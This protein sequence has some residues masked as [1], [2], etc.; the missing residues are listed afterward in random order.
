M[1]ELT[2][3]NEEYILKIRKRIHEYWNSVDVK[4]YS[5]ICL[6]ASINIPKLLV[7]Q[8]PPPVRRANDPLAHLYSITRPQ[9]ETNESS[10]VR[11]KRRAA[12]EER[13]RKAAKKTQLDR[14]HEDTP[15]YKTTLEA[16]RT[17]RTALEG[18]EALRNEEV[19]R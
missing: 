6:L 11:A 4:P 16:I 18:E 12:E 15:G 5:T 14:A 19:I 10:G 13:N 3:R 7:W 1:L 2:S 8:A 17:Y 9:R